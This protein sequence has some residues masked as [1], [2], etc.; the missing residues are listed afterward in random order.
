VP[1]EIALASH[2]KLDQAAPIAQV[3]DLRLYVIIFGTP[4]RYGYMAVQMKNFIDQTLKRTSSY[5]IR[6]RREPQ[7]PL[8][9][10]SGWRHF[11]PTFRFQRLSCCAIGEIARVEREDLRIP[12]RRLSRVQEMR[13]SSALRRWTPGRS[14]PAGKPPRPVLRAGDW[15]S[16]PLADFLSYHFF[17]SYCRDCHLFPSAPV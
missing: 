9:A 13:Q 15:A 16:P 14:D 8:T 10:A 11:R 2:Y 12:R 3:N 17:S 5:C 4:M 7:V 1:R 6:L